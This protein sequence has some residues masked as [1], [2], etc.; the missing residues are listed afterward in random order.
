M[1]RLKKSGFTLIELLIVLIIVGTVITLVSL[2]I[3]AKPSIAKHAASQLQGLLELARDEAVLKG[4]VLGFKLTAENFS[5]YRYREK[6]WQ[7]IV[8]DNLLR[9]YQ[10]HPGLDYQLTLDNAKVKNDKDSLPQIIL[11]PDGSLNN[12]E[13]IIQPKDHSESYKV[14][15]MRGKLTA[16]LAEDKK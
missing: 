13:L 1:P 12:F 14:T 11:L 8:K 7:P 9:S 15:I 16:Q 3:G 4:Q 5:F 6:L 10:L 2:N